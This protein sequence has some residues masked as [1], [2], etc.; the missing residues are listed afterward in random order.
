MA[1][2]CDPSSLSKKQI[3]V[4]ASVATKLPYFFKS[5]NVHL[6][7]RCLNKSIDQHLHR[8]QYITRRNSNGL[9]TFSVGLFIGSDVL[10]PIPVNFSQ[11]I[12]GTNNSNCPMTFPYIWLCSYA[13]R[14]K[15]FHQSLRLEIS[16][17]NWNVIVLKVMM[18]VREKLKER[19][20]EET[21]TSDAKSKI[22]VCSST[23]FQSW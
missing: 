23:S 19:I 3:Q 18:C 21:L 13:M 15:Y 12:S 9:Q 5:Y 17:Q 8:E 6:K 10:N 4:C 20:T 1:E 2:A 7:A 11:S 22:K 16:K 14:E